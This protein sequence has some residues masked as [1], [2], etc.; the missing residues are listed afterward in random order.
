MGNGAK[1]ASVCPASRASLQTKLDI[2]QGTAQRSST[3]LT[4]NECCPPFNVINCCNSRIAC[5][6]YLIVCT[7]CALCVYV[8]YPTTRCLIMYF[9]TIMRR[10]WK[11]SFGKHHCVV[12]A[13]HFVQDAAPRAFYAYI[14]L[15]FEEEE[16]KNRS[17]I[18]TLFAQ[19]TRREPTRSTAKYTKKRIQEADA[20][21]HKQHTKKQTTQNDDD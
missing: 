12:L 18:F 5:T 11:N 13:P 17:R 1:R 10:V 14:C 6:S 7:D 19:H 2:N 8:C 16:E 9:G 3:H 20:C 4:S 21:K 15:M